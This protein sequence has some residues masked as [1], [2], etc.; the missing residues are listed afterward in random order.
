MKKV[1]ETKAGT[2]EEPRDWKADFYEA[3]FERRGANDV[4]KEMKRVWDLT[5]KSEA[6]KGPGMNYAHDKWK[7]EMDG[8]QYSVER[9][10]EKIEEISGEHGSRRD[11][12][13]FLTYAA[14]RFMKETAQD[15]FS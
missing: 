14:G 11:Q 15:L 13:E 4:Y 3:Y 5:P 8:W 6:R 2:E 7:K 9:L 10:T 1:I 12:I